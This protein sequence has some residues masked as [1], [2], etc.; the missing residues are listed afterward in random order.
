MSVNLLLKAHFFAVAF[1]LGVVGVEFILE[2]DRA[3]SRA[4][5]FQVAHAH[6]QIDRWLEIPAFTV[7]L[8]SGLALVTPQHLNDWFLVKVVAGGM[9]VAANVACYLPVVKRQQAAR[10]A[11]LSEVIRYSRQ[12][13]RIS[14]LAV[15]AGLLALVL[16]MAL[17]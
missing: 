12:I 13:D 3:R 11:N 4:Q 2:R 15:P 16:A 1:W 7:V 6:R 9:A 8:L 10:A 14:A 5:S 17:P